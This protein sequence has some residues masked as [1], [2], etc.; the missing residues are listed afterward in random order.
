[1][2]SSKSKKTIRI[3][4]NAHETVSYMKDIAVEASELKKLYEDYTYVFD[5]YIDRYSDIV[6]NDDGEVDEITYFDEKT[7]QW[8]NVGNLLDADEDEDEADKS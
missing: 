7:Q 5:Q 6:S 2:T 8:K 3:R 1:M 4:I